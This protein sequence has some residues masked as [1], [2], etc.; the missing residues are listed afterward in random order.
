MSD[1]T[2]VAS[3]RI[4]PDVLIVAPYTS[5]PGSTST[6]TDSPVSIDWSIALVP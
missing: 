2:F 6:G 1:P 3:T 4:E 5:S